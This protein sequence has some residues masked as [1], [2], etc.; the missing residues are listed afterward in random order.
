MGIYDAKLETTWRGAKR[1]E[2][3]PTAAQVERQEEIRAETKQIVAERRSLVS[4]FKNGDPAFLEDGT[5][6]KVVFVFT[7]R[8]SASVLLPSGRE[9]SV[10]LA[11]LSEE[12]K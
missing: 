4:K 3:F 2:H 8:G 7:K 1:F 10:S 6:V 5:P 11:V 12:A 9:I